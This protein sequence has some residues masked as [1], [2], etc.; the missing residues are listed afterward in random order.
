LNGSKKWLEKG[1]DNGVIVVSS[2]AIGRT[3]SS[4]SYINYNNSFTDSSADVG[5]KTSWRHFVVVFVV[6]SSGLHK[7]DDG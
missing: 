1:C 4:G 3:I 5:I 2:M 7:D 6:I